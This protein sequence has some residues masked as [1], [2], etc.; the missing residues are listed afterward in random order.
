M[1]IFIRDLKSEFLKGRL[2]ASY[3]THYSTV[4]YGL[5]NFKCRFCFVEGNKADYRGVIPG[6]KV[7]SYEEIE[8]WVNAEAKR[9]IPIKITGGEPALYPVTTVNLLNAAKRHGTYTQLDTNGSIPEA[10]RQFAQ[11]VDSIG[12]DVKGDESHIEDLTCASKELSFYKP[13]ETLEL[14]K[15]FPCSIELKTVMFDFTDLKFLEW[16]YEKIPEK[17]YWEWKQYR[18]YEGFDRKPKNDTLVP[19]SEE[20]MLRL[21]KEMCTRHPDLKSRMVAIVGS[22]RDYNNFRTPKDL[23]LKP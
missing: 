13:L 21:M 8:G 6:S 2:P 3:G 9:G 19:A 12:L 10:A 15:N 16:L 20:Q 18:P 11:H 7:M 4:L 1:E 5:C 14:A 23:G 17:A 22:G